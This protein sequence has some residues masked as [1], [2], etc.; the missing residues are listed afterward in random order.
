MD[1][2]IN[3]QVELCPESDHDN[4]AEKHLSNSLDGF[5]IIDMEELITKDPVETVK[6][7][8]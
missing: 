7:K 5:E 1:Q 3:E 6:L 8:I 2:W 4:N